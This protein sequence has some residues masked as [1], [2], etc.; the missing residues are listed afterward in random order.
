MNYPAAIKTP[1]FVSFVVKTSSQETRKSQLTR[2]LP[3][4]VATLSNADFFMA[5]NLLAMY[6]L[7]H[8]GKDRLSS[9]SNW[10]G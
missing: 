1:N 7:S 2:A 10:V 6:H 9:V 3:S 8:W 5:L 4:I